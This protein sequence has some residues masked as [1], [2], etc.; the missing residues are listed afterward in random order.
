MQ[1]PVIVVAASIVLGAAACNRAEFDP[2]LAAAGRE[3]FHAEGC[4]ACHG[5]DGEGTHVGPSLDGVGRHWT[6]PELRRFLADPAGYPAGRRLDRVRAA[7]R[8]RM[9]AYRL[10][11]PARAEAL[12]SFLLA[13]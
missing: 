1:A 9:P 4:V 3:V 10:R 13:R 11:D 5:A 8:S 12:T 2:D 7:Y 6:G